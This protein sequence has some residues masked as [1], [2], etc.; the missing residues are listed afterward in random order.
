[1]Y[2]VRSS[3][4]GGEYNP[5]DVSSKKEGRMVARNRI[6]RCSNCINMVHASS[7]VYDEHGTAVLGYTCDSDANYKIRRMTEQDLFKRSE[8]GD[9]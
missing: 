1:M 4:S 5:Y 7:V 8:H 3:W 9:R 6:E 2:T